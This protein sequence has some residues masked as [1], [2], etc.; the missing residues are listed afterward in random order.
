M[1][2]D[3]DQFAAALLAGAVPTS[4]GSVALP[5]RQVFHGSP[6]DWRDEVL[7]FLLVDRFSDGQEA[8]RRALDR[9]NL[10]RD[11]PDGQDGQAWR[12]DRWATSGAD[13][14]QVREPHDTVIPAR[15]PWLPRSAA[16]R[17]GRFR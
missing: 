16:R 1:S 11:R 2:N 14:W 6:V 10:G 12:W 15:V 4:V 13:R 7:Y 9:S 3:H 8:A 5:R 17:R